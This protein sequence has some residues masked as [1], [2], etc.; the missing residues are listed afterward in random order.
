MSAELVY[1]LVDQVLNLGD[2]D[3]LDTLLSPDCRHHVSVVAG[4]S[5][6]PAGL[7]PFV[8]LLRDVF[9]EFYCTAE[10]CCTLEEGLEVFPWTLRGIHR[11]EFLGLPATFKPVSVRGE[12]RLRVREGK[13]AELWLELSLAALLR[14]LGA[15]IQDGL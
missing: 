13:I 7:K 15:P 14:Q 6:G 1:R 11:S 5:P 8:A 3:D 10:L 2:L 4:L 12:L 9:A